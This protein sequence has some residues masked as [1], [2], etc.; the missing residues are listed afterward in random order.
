MAVRTP[1]LF[2]ACPKAK[3]RPYQRPSHCPPISHRA[4]VAWWVNP[5]SDVNCGSG[6][7]GPARRLRGQS[8]S[9]LQ[10]SSWYTPGHTAPLWSTQG[11]EP[12]G[13]KSAP[14]QLPQNGLPQSSRFP[15]GRGCPRVQQ[16]DTAAETSPELQEQ[17][18][19]CT[20]HPNT[21]PTKMQG[22]VRPPG[23]SGAPP[24]RSI[25]CWEERA[26]R[27]ARRTPEG[28][29]GRTSSPG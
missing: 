29:R 2:P 15:T 13:L 12:G 8:R 1:A 20:P 16:E 3:S 17:R 5:V 19:K 26:C 10:S 24:S 6:V 18:T 27:S 22:W 14:T 11:W 4:P 25:Y 9:G 7:S 21:Y 23:P 28:A